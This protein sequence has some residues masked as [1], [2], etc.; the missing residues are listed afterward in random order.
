MATLIYTAVIGHKPLQSGHNLHAG[1][2][3]LKRRE[4][5]KA[6]VPR[7]GKRPNVVKRGGQQHSPRHTQRLSSH[8][9]TQPDTRRLRPGT[10][11]PP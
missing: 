2:A 1:R 6:E 10:N 8:L 9:D 7:A 3:G 4:E 11:G 5:K